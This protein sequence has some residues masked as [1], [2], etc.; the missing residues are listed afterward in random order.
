MPIV[1]N[2]ITTLVAKME[3]KSPKEANKVPRM[4]IDR[5]PYLFVSPLAMGP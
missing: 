1:K 4:V 3:V 5:H 2:S